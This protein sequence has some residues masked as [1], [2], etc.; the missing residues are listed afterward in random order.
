MRKMILRRMILRRMMSMRIRRR[1][2][3]RCHPSLDNDERMRGKDCD[4]QQRCTGIR[5]AKNRHVVVVVVVWLLYC[6]YVGVV[7]CLFACLLASG[8]LGSGSSQMAHS[9][10][11][12]H[13]LSNPG[14]ERALHHHGNGT[15]R[16]TGVI[17]DTRTF[18][19]YDDLEHSNRFLPDSERTTD[20]EIPWTG[21]Q[22]QQTTTNNKRRQQTANNNRHEEEVVEENN[23]GERGGGGQC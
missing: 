11:L 9:V 20:G 6:E 22:Q 23:H 1:R 12:T 17:R 7:V 19:N 21:L 8:G 16:P 13:A 10:S 14:S 4:S 18:W 2:R 15:I 3:I 5:L